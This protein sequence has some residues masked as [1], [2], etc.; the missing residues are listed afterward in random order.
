MSSDADRSP[1]AGMAERI[2]ANTGTRL[3]EAEAPP[4]PAVIAVR[5]AK[6]ALLFGMLDL[7]RWFAPWQVRLDDQDAGQLAADNEL[8]L[9]TPP[10]DHRLEL[11]C[12]RLGSRTLHFTARREQHLYFHARGRFSLLG[13]LTIPLLAL[14]RPRTYLL[15]TR[16]H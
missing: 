5:R 3:P 8:V 16:L 7:S 10:G 12:G 14:L 15:L 13:W 9:H 11:R 2:L 4:A 1:Y 6:V